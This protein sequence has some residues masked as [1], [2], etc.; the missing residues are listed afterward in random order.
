MSEWYMTF[1]GI[2][3]Y[4]FCSE[5][6]VLGGGES[7]KG[8]DI[9]RGRAHLKNNHIFLVIESY[10]TYVVVTRRLRTLHPHTHRFRTLHNE[11]S[12]KGTKDLCGCKEETE[13]L[14]PTL[15]SSPNSS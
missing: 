7:Y 5:V 15:S 11:K 2:R 6:L 8:T 4:L 1:R 10:D 14:T 12:T 9:V 13:N 3:L